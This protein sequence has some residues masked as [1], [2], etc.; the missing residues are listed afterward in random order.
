MKNKKQETF[1]IRF[2]SEPSIKDP[3]TITSDIS[4]AVAGVIPSKGFVDL[5]FNYCNELSD[6]KNIGICTKCATRMAEE[7]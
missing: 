4:R 3:R 6:Q 1:V 7:E 5:S 2:G